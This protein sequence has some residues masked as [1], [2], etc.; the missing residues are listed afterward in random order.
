MGCW[1]KEALGSCVEKHSRKVTLAQ[2]PTVHFTHS[3]WRRDWCG[4]KKGPHPPFQKMKI[5]IK[6][7]VETQQQSC[8]SLWLSCLIL[9][10]V[11]APLRQWTW[12]VE[13]S[14]SSGQQQQGSLL[15]SHYITFMG[16]RHDEFQFACFIKIKGEEKWSCQLPPSPAALLYIMPAKE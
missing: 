3:L 10:E 13:E 1:N 5:K 12:R 4:I 8:C 2:D 16:K 14:V 15:S 7:E 6:V 11:V 9:F